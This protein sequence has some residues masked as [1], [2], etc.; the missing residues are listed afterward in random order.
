MVVVVSVCCRQEYP[1]VT[2][3]NEAIDIVF[4]LEL[5]D[6]GAREGKPPSPLYRRSAQDKSISA[7]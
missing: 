5:V 7:R 2:S 4:Y 1:S 6:Q 3:D